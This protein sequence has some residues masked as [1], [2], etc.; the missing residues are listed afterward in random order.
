MAVWT[1]KLRDAGLGFLAGLSPVIEFHLNAP[2]VSNTMVWATRPVRAAVASDGDFSVELA[3]T[4]VM[5]GDAYY[6]M[7]A[8]WLEPGTSLAQG[9]SASDIHSDI[10]IRTN[11]AGGPI[12]D[13]VGGISN[14]SLVLVS[15]TEPP[16]LRA[17]QLWWKT[18][19]TD[20]YGPE[21]TGLIYV[22]GN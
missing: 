4:S 12:G 22:G 9:Y 20:P 3:D 10:Q 6:T 13:A 5:F 15:L 16:H 14:N 21:N 1:G 19:P 17:G 7:V 11:G 8:R 18:D 2:H